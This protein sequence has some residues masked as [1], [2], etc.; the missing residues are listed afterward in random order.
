MKI[1]VFNIHIANS[2]IENAEKIKTCS[3]AAKDENFRLYE[4]FMK[5]RIIWDCDM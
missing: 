3:K 5:F 2:S 4:I 1:Y